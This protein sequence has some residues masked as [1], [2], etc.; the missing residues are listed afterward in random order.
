[1]FV[2]MIEGHVADVDRLH[3]Q[4]D[5]WMKTLRPGTTGYLGST[6]G[7]SDDGTGMCFARFE[8][9]DAARA[10]SERPE[11]GEW[12]ADTE[13]CFD[14]EVSFTDSEDVGAL[15]GGGSNDAEFVQVMK[16][17]DVDHDQI[18]AMDREFESVASTFRPDLL[19]STRV[20]TGP[21]ACVEV[22]YF[23]NE[24]EAR[25]GEMK[26]IPPELADRAGEFEAMMKNTGFIDIRQPWL[27]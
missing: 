9:A 27:Y 18:H 17:H 14:G 24:A 15:L 1:M 16:S 13:S 20:W 12:W 6:A 8:S 3:R 2:Q 25:E 21:D 5:K 11:Q 26:G 23:T 19:G 4:M 10:N 7:V 22:A